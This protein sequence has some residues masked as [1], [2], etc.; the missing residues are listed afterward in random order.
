MA[1]SNHPD[2]LQD[3]AVVVSLSESSRNFKLKGRSCRAV[4]LSLELVGEWM[5]WVAEYTADRINA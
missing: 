2:T 4:D 1:V 3:Y 5:R